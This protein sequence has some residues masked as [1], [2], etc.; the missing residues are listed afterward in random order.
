MPN[1]KVK[2]DI[3]RDPSEAIALL[4]KIKKKHGD[5]GDASPLN[6]LEGD[7]I[8]PAQVQAAE[9]DGKADDFRSKAE[10]EIGERNKD[11]PVVKEGLRSVRDVLLGLN[12]ARPEETHR[13]VL[14]R[15]RGGG[16][17]RRR[18][19]DGPCKIIQ[20]PPLD[21]PHRPGRLRLGRR[22]LCRG[23]RCPQREPRR[24]APERKVCAEL[25]GGG[26]CNMSKARLFSP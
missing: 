10:T 3:P 15:E 14:R 26:G 2:V 16:R 18:G 24:A 4:G 17:R 6:G 22:F 11:V 20:R 7:K 9:H 19:Q 13:M 8:G 23:S 25:G 21:S 1:N 5:L 12:R